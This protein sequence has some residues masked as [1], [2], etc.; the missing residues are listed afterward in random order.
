MKQTPKEKAK[1]LFDHYY[2]LIQDIG[3]ELGQEILVSILAEQCA[4]FFAKQMQQEKWDEKKYKSHSY[5]EEVEVE[6]VNIGM[7]AM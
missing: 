5:W 3:G 6:I 4:L 2:I 7:Y 1:Q